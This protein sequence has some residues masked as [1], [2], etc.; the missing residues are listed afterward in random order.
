MRALRITAKHNHAEL[1]MLGWAKPLFSRDMQR[2]YLGPLRAAG[3]EAYLQ[4]FT[5]NLRRRL[6]LAVN[7][8]CL[9]DV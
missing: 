8:G 3:P 9:R 2:R 6:V 5:A 4:K 1:A 7:Y